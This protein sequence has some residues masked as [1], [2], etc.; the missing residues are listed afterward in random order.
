MPAPVSVKQLRMM[1]AILAGKKGQTSRGDN[2][3]PKSIA[4]KYSGGSDKDLPETK[5]KEMKGGRWSAGSGHHPDSKKKDK[6]K[7]HVKKSN[8]PYTQQ[9]YEPV[10]GL[11]RGAGVI[12]TMGGQVL[13]GKQKEDGKWA[14]FGGKVE[15]LENFGEAAIRE[16]QEEA[17]I[18]AESMYEFT[19]SSG[20]ASTM[21]YVVDRFSGTPRPDEKEFTEVEWFDI[22]DIPFNNL[23]PCCVEPMKQFAM[24]ALHKSKNLE[25]MLFLEELS[26]NIVRSEVGSDVVADMS[27]GDALRLVGNGTFRMLRNAVKDMESE[28]FRN[29]TVDNYTIHIRKHANDVYSG[30]VTDGHK[31]IHQFTNKSLPSISAELMSIFEWYLP[32]DEKELE[33]VDDLHDAD[34]EGGLNQLID[35]YKKHNIANIYDEMN[36]I[37]L[38]IRNGM[39]IDLQ[40][41]EQRIMKLFDKLENTLHGITT[42]HN[43]LCQDSSKEL[44][45]VHQKLV[46]LQSKID[47]LGRTPTKIEAVS[48]R[49]IDPNHIHDNYYNYLSK[50]H[51][52]IDPNGKMRILFK[53]DWSSLDT[54]NFLHDMKARILSKS[55]K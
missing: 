40:Q 16:L 31:Q 6:H 32:E 30:R 34:I 48:A 49:N 9:A 7:K 20:T 27:H 12:V 50:P 41:C 14:G 55:R 21:T 29:L 28:G 2:G 5:G 8:D 39:A 11:K 17:G 45:M 35:N 51:V 15:S 25:D 10:L 42:K 22:K 44:D 4:A 24:K 1:H 33:I 18:R 26:K 36:N 13:L 38:E 52:E 23:R 46:Q 53:S 37:R 54:T 3:P 19:P 43:K 47:E